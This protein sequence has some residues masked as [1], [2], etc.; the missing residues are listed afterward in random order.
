MPK[1]VWATFCQGKVELSEP[2]AISEGTRILV[3]I[4]PDDE[5]EFWLK[6]S[7]TSLAAVWDNDEDDI[8]AQLH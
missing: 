4:L 6:A 5:S 1:T 7:Q 2:I 8:Y 3:T